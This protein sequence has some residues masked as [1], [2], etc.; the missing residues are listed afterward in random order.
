MIFKK[1][2]GVSA[3]AGAVLLATT[4][5]ALAG[6][7]DKEEERDVRI[8]EK[9]DRVCF[10]RSI[11]GFSHTEKRS[12]VLRKGVSKEYYVETGSCFNL[13]RALSIGIDSRGGGC[14]SRGDYLIVSESAFGLK[15]NTGIGPDRCYIKAIYEWNEDAEAEETDTE[16]SEETT[17]EDVS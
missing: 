7:R 5:A 11:D 4:S 10:S 3:I 15:D 1:L 9:V 14:L 8:G 16:E 17:T 6:D 12:V 2:S 13:R